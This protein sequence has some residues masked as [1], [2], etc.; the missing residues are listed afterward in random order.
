MVGI[1]A[2]VWIITKKKFIKTNQTKPNRLGESW[3]DLNLW[4]D[5]I[6]FDIFFIFKKYSI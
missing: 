6:R 4:T 1:G 3:I 2:G 5:M